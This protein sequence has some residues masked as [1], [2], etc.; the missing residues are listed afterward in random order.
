MFAKNFAVNAKQRENR[1]I[2]DRCRV[3]LSNKNSVHK[4]Q[5]IRWRLRRRRAK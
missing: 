5:P 2:V 1:A 4:R 3:G